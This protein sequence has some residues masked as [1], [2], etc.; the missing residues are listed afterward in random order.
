M[1]DLVRSLAQVVYRGKERDYRG[2]KIKSFLVCTRMPPTAAQNN[3][4]RDMLAVIVAIVV[5]YAIRALC[6]MM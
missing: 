5:F 4:A 6:A 1:I 2:K 3:I